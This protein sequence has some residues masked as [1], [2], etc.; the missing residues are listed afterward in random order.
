[1]RGEGGQLNNIVDNT[2]VRKYMMSLEGYIMRKTL[3]LPGLDSMA[4]LQY[5]VWAETFWIFWKYV[6]FFEPREKIKMLVNMDE[7]F[8]RLKRG[9]IRKTL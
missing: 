6:K 8:L 5:V 9:L 3:L 7:I 1:M 4:K 2:T